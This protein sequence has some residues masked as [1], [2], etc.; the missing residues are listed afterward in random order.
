VLEVWGTSLGH[1]TPGTPV[2]TSATKALLEVLGFFTGLG[3]SIVFFAAV[4]LGRFS[5]VSVKDE[6][7][8]AADYEMDQGGPGQV[9][10]GQPDHA[11]GQDQFPATTGQFPATSGQYPATP[12]QYPT[13]PGPYTA[14]R[15]GPEAGQVRFPTSTGQFPPPAKDPFPPADPFPPSTR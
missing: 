8:D 10:T 12:G 3:F 7:D 13:T 11:A 4:A 6:I 9:P 14:S 15:P 5:I 1:V 2:A